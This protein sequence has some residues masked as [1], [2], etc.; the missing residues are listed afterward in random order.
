MTTKGP[1][2]PASSLQGW[3]SDLAR[4]VR[5]AQRLVVFSGA[6][7]SQESGL[8]TFRGQ[9][10]LW[11]RFRPE[12]L[13]TPEAFAAR[14]EVVWG[15]YASRFHKAAAA[16]PNPAHV[17]IARM[18]ELFPSISVVTQNVDGLHLL[19]GSQRVLEVHGTLRQARC[20]G[21]GRRRDMREAVEE[22]PSRPPRCSCGGLFRPAVVWFGEALPEEVLRLAALDSQG[23]DLFLSVGT[24]A[25]VYPAA[26]L[27]DVACRA[28]ACLV[29][30][31]PEPTPFT[32]QAHLHLAAPAGEALPRLFDLFR[33][34]RRGEEE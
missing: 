31:N 22:S 33:Q 5:L 10:G 11:Q 6:G 30:V 29:E 28:G 24:S 18:E 26:G 4:R 20:H 15:W 19:A 32:S 34:A 9:E 23:A 14:P 16:Q 21:C 3:S 1:F 13:A 17:A 25:R 8:A 2:E 7:V 27:I 12:E